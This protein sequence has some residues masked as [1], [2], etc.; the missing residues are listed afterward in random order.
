MQLISIQQATTR[1]LLATLA[2]REPLLLY[3]HLD[4]RLTKQLTNASGKPM[5]N[6]LLTVKEAATI[7]G[8]STSTLKR[9]CESESI[10]FIRTPGGHRRIDKMDL[11]RVATKLHLRRHADTSDLAMVQQ[12]SSEQILSNLLEGKAMEIAKLLS[13][14]SNTPFE[15]VQALEDCLVCALWK[16]GEMWRDKRIDVYQEH[17]CTNAAMTALDYLRQQ[18][19]L[20][21]TSTRTAV[22]GSL[23][24]SVETLPSKLVGLSLELIGIRAIDLGGSLPPESL[25]QAARDLQASVVWVTHTHV[26]DIESLLASHKVLR[27]KL[28]QETRVIVG[29]GALSPALRRS[30]HWCEFYETISQMLQSELSRTA[31]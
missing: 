12:I 2:A 26:C 28:P 22:G 16:V 25:A 10:P 24:P 9:M 17:I 27:E 4:E 11:N 5:R 3:L 6:E 23:D 18:L 8:V 20:E 13:R 1:I 30:L 7:V 21:S 14:S 29:G 15:L 19:P 31:R